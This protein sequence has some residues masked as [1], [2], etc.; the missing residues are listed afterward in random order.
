MK[1][2]S[3]KLSIKEFV[4]LSAYN[5][6]LRSNSHAIS[7]LELSREIAP[8]TSATAFRSLLWNTPSTYGSLPLMFGERRWQAFI[9]LWWDTP[10]LAGLP[11]SMAMESMSRTP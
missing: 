7:L 2:E 9:H 11:A 8:A 5:K 1:R 4:E 3:I 6:I 10:S